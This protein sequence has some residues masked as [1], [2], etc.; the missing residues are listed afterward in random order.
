MQNFATKLSPVKRSKRIPILF[1]LLQCSLY[2]ACINDDVDE[3]S[4]ATHKNYKIEFGRDTLYVKASMWGL[5]G[6]HIQIVFSPY[7][8]ESK[9]FDSSVCFKYFEPTVYY[10]KNGDTLELYP[11]MKSDVPGKLNSN[12][13]IKQTI[14]NKLKDIHRYKEKYE[15][16]GLEKI[17]VYE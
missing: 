11:T 13:K 9:N 12:I 17:S 1:I 16:Y 6:G 8:F 3:I 2:H 14:I 5:A 15:A 7:P 4:K 10:K